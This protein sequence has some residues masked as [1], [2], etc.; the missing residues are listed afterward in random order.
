MAVFRNHGASCLQR[1]LKWFWEKICIYVYMCIYICIY[2]YNLR[3]YMRERVKITK[4]LLGTWIK[5]YTS[6]STSLIS[7]SIT[8]PDPPAIS[9]QR[10]Q[11][12]PVFVIGNKHSAEFSLLC[13]CLICW[14][15][16]RPSQ[17][18]YRP[19]WTWRKKSKTREPNNRHGGNNETLA[20]N[21]KTL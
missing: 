8:I 19:S 11:P 16:Q 14:R 9:T 13:F 4:K 20:P 1:T 6:S 3:I 2:I 7:V 5:C 18:F 17:V 12:L 15:P 10:S 21:Y